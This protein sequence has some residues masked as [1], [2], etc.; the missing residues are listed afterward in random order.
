MGGAPWRDRRLSGRRRYRDRDESPIAARAGA[1]DGV[2]MSFVVRLWVTCATVVALLAAGGP[3]PAAARDG[4]GG[5]DDGRREARVAG[6]C[7]KGASSKLRLRSRD[8]E[9]SVEFEVKRRRGGE[10]WRVVLVH[11]RRV[12]WRGVRTT[13][14]S[15]SFR[16]RRTLRDLGGSDRVKVR[17]SGPRGVTCEAAA[18][19]AA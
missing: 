15:G 11:E 6:T 12:A 9:I 4:G 14:S 18:T 1:G 13:G 16:V 19:L 8:G 5:D 3:A 7:G 10:R 2:D 17:G